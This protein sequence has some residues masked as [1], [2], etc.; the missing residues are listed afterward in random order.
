MDKQNNN[1]VGM[2][3]DAE[4]LQFVYGKMYWRRHVVAVESQYLFAHVDSIL[5]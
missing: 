4:I 2:E 3:Q 1:N 5:A